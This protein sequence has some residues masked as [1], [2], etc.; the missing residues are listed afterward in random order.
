MVVWATSVW[1]PL[2]LV[3]DVMVI[4]GLVRRAVARLAGVRR[5]WWLVM[6]AGGERRLVVRRLVAGRLIRGLRLVL[7]LMR[8][9]RREGSRAR[10]PG[11][12]RVDSGCAIRRLAT[13]LVL[14]G[15]MNRASNDR[16]HVVERG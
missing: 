12:V 11:L 15:T 8:R 3:Q 5:P 14:L 13:P 9:M 4:T 16:A 7:R 1:A 10:G 6:E 2:G